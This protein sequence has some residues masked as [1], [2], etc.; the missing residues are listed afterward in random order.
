MREGYPAW[1]ALNI[2]RAEREDIP[3][4]AALAA[5]LVRGHHAVDPLRFMLPDE[6]ERGYRVW[7]EQEHR[8]AS[9]VMRVAEGDGGALVGYTY[10]RLEDRD[11]NSLLDAFGALHDLYVDENFRGAG[12]GEAL[13]RATLD[14]LRTL[15]APRCV[16]QT[17]WGNA[18]A[19]RLFERVGFRR[20]MVEM[21]CELAP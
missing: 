4:M 17:M 19:Q 5:R 3:A 15:G 12:I 10:A 9:V 18:V 1:I 13:V 14:L 20:T 8:R 2:R 16:L 21:T 7:F 6:V 11:W